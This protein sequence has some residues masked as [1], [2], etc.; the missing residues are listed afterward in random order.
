MLNK[1]QVQQIGELFVREGV[2]TAIGK[3]YVYVC[4][5]FAISEYDNNSF[6]NYPDCWAAWTSAHQNY[7]GKYFE[8]QPKEIPELTCSLINGLATL[9]VDSVGSDFVS[10]ITPDLFAG[11][12]NETYSILGPSDASRRKQAYDNL[13]ILAVLYLRRL[14]YMFDYPKRVLRIPK[15]DM[16]RELKTFSAEIWRL[17]ECFFGL[18]GFNDQ[19]EKLWLATQGIPYNPKPISTRGLAAISDDM[20]KQGF[21]DE[22][23]LKVFFCIKSLNKFDVG[24][25]DNLYAYTRNVFLKE[26]QARLSDESV[27]DTADELSP[28]EVFFLTEDKF[29]KQYKAWKKIDAIDFIRGLLFKRAKSALEIENNIAFS[30]LKKW[31][32]VPENLQKE[33]QTIRSNQPRGRFDARR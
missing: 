2:N 7:L 11:D 28:G 24:R 15:E 4:S 1:A 10:E 27:T 22:D 31:L 32:A 9:I 26:H 13:K 8:D 14:S 18:L 29:R 12:V 20:N 19:F 3:F 23:I 17:N 33:N 5:L 21:S 6:R 16:I 30:H 25:I